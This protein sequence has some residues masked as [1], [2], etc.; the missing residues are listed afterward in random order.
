VQSIYLHSSASTPSGPV[1]SG[2]AGQEILCW[3]GE[4]AHTLLQW[5]T[6]HLAF[7]I[8]R[9]S[10][11]SN[12]I[13]FLHFFKLLLDPD[14]NHLVDMVSCQ[15]FHTFSTST[16]SASVGYLQ[17]ASSVQSVLQEST[18]GQIALQIA[19]CRVQRQ[20]AG[21]FDRVCLTCLLST[22]TWSTLQIPTP[23]GA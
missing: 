16:A 8:G 18:C 14:G 6:V 19:S 4:K 21:C 1:L 22:M 15:S 13:D 23:H 2:P 10:V 12:G 9:G 17:T 3:G 11:S 5:E 7:P 20:Y